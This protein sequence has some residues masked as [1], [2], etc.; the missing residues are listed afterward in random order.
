MLCVVEWFSER[1]IGVI[2]INSINYHLEEK[3]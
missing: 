2:L 3:G 1:C